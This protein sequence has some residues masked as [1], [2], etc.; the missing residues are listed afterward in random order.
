MIIA[1]DGPAASGKGTLARKLAA[2][3]K[4]GYLDTGA[5]YRGVAR[6]VMARGFRVRDTW[7][8]VA[9]ARS[10]DPT[11]LDDEG[12][13]DAGVGEA[14]SVIA[15]IPMVRAA[16]LDYQRGFARQPGGA[17]LDGRDVG[18]VVCPHADGKLFVTATPEVRAQRRHAERL[19]RGEH[20]TFEAVLQL[21]HDRDARDAGRDASPMRPAADA[22]L[23]D[24]THLDISQA[25]DAAVDAISRKIIR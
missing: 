17:V 7:A 16:L 23:L 14:A 3:F 18:T 11:T 21:I 6:D 10:L 4:L 5:L 25:L 15:R 24:T 20:L 13:R 9:M 19:A 12:L 1:V 22:H 8:A 2:H